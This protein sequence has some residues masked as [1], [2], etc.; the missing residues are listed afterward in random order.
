LTTDVT[1]NEERLSSWVSISDLIQRERY[2]RDFGMWD[3]M[4]DCYHPDSEVEVLW[5]KGSGSEFAAAS[6]EAADLGLR[7]IHQTSSSLITIR[8]DRALCDTG[9]ETHILTKLDD[10][11]MI[12]SSQTRLLARVERRNGNW[13]FVGFRTLF[14]WD[15]LAPVSPGLNGPILILEEFNSL[16][17][18]YRHLAYVMARR[19]QKL[20]TDLP[21]VDDPST[22]RVLRTKEQCWLLDDRIHRSKGHFDN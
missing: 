8:N 5:F 12:V 18:S 6:Q 10:V 13:R 1:N 19:G 14:V 20:P 16:R 11:E 21:G 17:P 15:T 7:S 9:C 3:A 22:E 4:A 2:A